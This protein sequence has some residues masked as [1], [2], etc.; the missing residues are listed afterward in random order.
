[1]SEVPEMERDCAV[2]NHDVLDAIKRAQEHDDV[3]L[4]GHP[5]TRDIAAHLP[6]VAGASLSLGRVR[7][8]LNMLDE[9]GLIEQGKSAVLARGTDS[10][11]AW[12]VEEDDDPDW[13][14][15]SLRGDADA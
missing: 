8:R 12:L 2:S 10:R 14:D 6:A 5:T 11:T 3:A 13:R 1:M 15:Y 9:A 4:N 7:C